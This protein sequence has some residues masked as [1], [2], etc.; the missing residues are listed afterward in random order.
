MICSGI[1]PKRLEQ[2]DNAT[3]L[4]LNSDNQNIIDSNKFKKYFKNRKNNTAYIISKKINHFSKKIKSE[5]KNQTKIIKENNNNIRN[6]NFRIF[7][8]FKLKKNMI[9]K[10]IL[11]I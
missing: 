4:I 2:N 7:L 3:S 1:T 9:L 5:K 11:I 6:N 8:Y 10:I